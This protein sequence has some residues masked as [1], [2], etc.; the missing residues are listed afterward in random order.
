MDNNITFLRRWF[1]EVGKLSPHKEREHEDGSISCEYT[2]EAFVDC[3]IVK[4]YRAAATGV[5]AVS[6]SPEKVLCKLCHEEIYF[7][8]ENRWVHKQGRPRHMA[9]PAAPAVSPEPTPPFELGRNPNIPR[10]CNACG[11]ILLLENLYVDDG[12]PCNSARGV[13][14]TPQPCGLCRLDCCVKPG[15]RLFQ[16]FGAADSRTP[17]TAEVLEGLKRDVLAELRRIRQ[18]WWKSSVAENLL[19]DAEPRLVALFDA[20]A[21]K[22]PTK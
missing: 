10:T 9:E 22:E 4:A 20:A 15:H 14:F 16:L 2:F 18:E 3:P 12:C 21:Q 19:E 11:R 8:T 13:N 17:A 5:A 6:P 7:S 1:D